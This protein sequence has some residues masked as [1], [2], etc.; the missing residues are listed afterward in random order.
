MS[1]LSCQVYTSILY[2]SDFEGKRG[3]NLD[4]KLK[5]F[6]RTFYLLTTTLASAIS[7]RKSKMR[8]LSLSFIETQTIIFIYHEIST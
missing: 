7:D 5:V 8:H 3:S 1:I 4:P 6:C 2:I